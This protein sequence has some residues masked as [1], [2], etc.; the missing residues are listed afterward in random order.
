MCT[1]KDAPE[2]I[3]HQLCKVLF[4]P[5]LF[6]CFTYKITTRQLNIKNRSLYLLINRVYGFI[7]EKN[8]N[9]SLTIDK[10][11]SVL[12]KNDQVFSGIKYH[13]GK[14]NL[15]TNSLMIMNLV[16]NFLKLFMIVVMTK[17]NS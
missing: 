16:T 13:I 14:L 12:K 10:G 15:V 2:K 8:D 9:K 1:R 7:S 11:D 4:N 6:Y 3:N 17:L 5:G